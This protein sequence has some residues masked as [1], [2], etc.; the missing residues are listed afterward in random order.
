MEFVLL[1]ILTQQDANTENI[2]VVAS[3]EADKDNI[4]NWKSG[5]RKLQV[6]SLMIYITSP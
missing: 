6:R 5:K 2:I 4:W 3:E 1:V